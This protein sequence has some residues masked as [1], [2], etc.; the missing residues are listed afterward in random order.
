[1]IFQ[2]MGPGWLF[3]FRNE[4]PYGGFEYTPVLS[5]YEAAKI[6]GKRKE[7]IIEIV[8]DIAKCSQEPE[9]KTLEIGLR[10]RLAQRDIEFQKKYLDILYREVKRKCETI[11][12][13]ED[14]IISILLII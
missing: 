9:K 11:K 7:E 14:E 4:Y 5:A 8:E 10:L 1:M 2:P 3:F 6:R 13:E 12:Q